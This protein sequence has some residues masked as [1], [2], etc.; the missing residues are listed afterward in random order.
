MLFELGAVKKDIIERVSKKRI[1][2]LIYQILLWQDGEFQFELDDLDIDGKVDV[3]DHGWEMSKGLSPEYLLM[4]GARVYDE[5]THGVFIPEEEFS[6]ETSDDEWDR[7]WAGREEDRRKDISSLKALTQELRFPNST[8]EITLLILRF[9]SDIFQRG[10]LFTVGERDIRGL[11]Q[12]GLDMEEADKKIRHIIFPYNKSPFL[13]GII[14]E[15]RSYKGA[16]EKDLVVELI[17]TELGEEWPQKAA[18]FPIIANEKVVALLYCDNQSSGEELAEAEGLEIFVSQ[19][20]L[21]LEKA[22]LH[23]RL[24]EL[25]KQEQK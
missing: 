16:I 9:A 4:E 10:V 13:S 15:G 14:R 5:T 25:E 2:R 19:A 24:K 7:E 18:F 12:F 11:G 17:F 20:G 21:A 3:T 1:E 8:S 23:R 22:I 6:A